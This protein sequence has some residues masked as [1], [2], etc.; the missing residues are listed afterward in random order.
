MASAPEN[1]VPPPLRQ[2]TLFISYA[3][4]DREAA[5]R[6]RDTLTA[7]GL[8]V[9]YDESELGGGDA[10]D[11]KIRRQI[12]DCDYFMPVISAAT[13]RRK[14]GYFRREWR[15]AAERTLDMADDVMFLLP[16]AIDGTSEA[17]AR[18]PDKFLAV[19]WLHLP[20]GR[21]TPALEALC[22]RLSAGEHS[23]PPPAPRGNARR[24]P[25]PVA[26]KTESAGGKSAARED[27]PPPMPPFPHPPEKGNLAHGLKF[28]AEAFWWLITAAWILFKRAPKI[29]R[30]LLSVWLAFAIVS[31]CGRSGHRDDEEAA[32]P[33]KPPVTITDSAKI[34]QAIE[35]ATRKAED[36]KTDSGAD[37]VQKLAQG[38]VAGLKE[39]AAD[40]KRL[41]LVPFTGQPGDEAQAKRLGAVFAPLYGRLALE[42]KDDVGV[43][44]APLKEETDAA[45]RERGQE[46]D[47]GFML[48][49]WIQV[50][51]GVPVLVVHLVKV[52][53]GALVWNG[54]FAMEFLQS[55]PGGVADKIATSVL[56]AVPKE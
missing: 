53:D 4:E 52:E 24:A 8:D 5:R 33:P 44:S 55:D 27:G 14:E 17:S 9:W 12:R 26:A 6:L 23:V 7:A 38:L 51:N 21:S 30:V 20:D 18:V 42:R 32:R 3:S 46:L 49:G 29:F 50:D 45:I 54:Q 36:T 56:A 10:W 22:R 13:E 11:Q 41:V 25:P 34:R 15:L 31:R 47:A 28:L 43:V 40:D 48:G 35:T 39:A 19:Q 37:Y 16:V 1:A 2:P